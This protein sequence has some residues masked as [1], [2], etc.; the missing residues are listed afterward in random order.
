MNGCTV[1]SGHSNEHVPLNVGLIQWEPTTNIE[2]EGYTSLQFIV[3]LRVRKDTDYGLRRGQRSRMS[4]DELRCLF[5]MDISSSGGHWSIAS[6][7]CH[8][9]SIP[10]YRIHVEKCQYRTASILSGAHFLN[11]KRIRIQSGQFIFNVR[12][13]LR[14][15]RSVGGSVASNLVIMRR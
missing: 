15:Q 11:T 12:S 3:A 5:L 8:Y 2:W 10:G 9:K 6:P 4:T 14:T 1:W 7:S 13:Q